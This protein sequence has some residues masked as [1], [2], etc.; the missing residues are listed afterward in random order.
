MHL[1]ATPAGTEG[2]FT[3][4]EQVT[5]AKIGA[6]TLP[7]I[8]SSVWIRY[9]FLFSSLFVPGPRLFIRTGIVSIPSI[10]V[11]LLGRGIRFS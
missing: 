4:F 3:V 7:P 10:L 1:I 5:P 6:P 8:S 11:S 9:S 2:R